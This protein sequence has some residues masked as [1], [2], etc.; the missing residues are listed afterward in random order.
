[1]R[2][3][4][5]IQTLHQIDQMEHTNH[6]RNQKIHYSTFIKNPITLQTSSNKLQLQSKHNFQT[7]HQTKFS[8]KQQKIM[9][10]HSK[11]QDILC[12]ATVQ[13]NKSEYKHQNKSQKIYSQN[14]KILFGSVRCLVKHL[15]KLF[16]TFLIFQISTSQKMI[17]FNSIFNRSNVK[18]SYSC[19]KN[20]KSII[21]N[22]NITTL[23]KSKTLSKE[24][25][26][27][28]NKNT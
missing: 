16:T 2:Q 5:T 25:C 23:N 26:N 8:V 14:H 17:N 19:T 9:K 20:I 12:Q 11:N 18:V 7:T 10:R 24:K 6:I 1:M 21:T 22:D 3:L 4:S 13:T 27:C 28:I 15:Q